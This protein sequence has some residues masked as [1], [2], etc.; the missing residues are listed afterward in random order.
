MTRGRLVAVGVG[1][2]LLAAV[3]WSQYWIVTGRVGTV[4]QGRLYR[5]AGLPPERLLGLVRQHNITTV[6]DFRKTGAETQAE[7]AAVEQAGIRYVPIPSEQVPS[8]DAVARFLDVMDSQSPGAVLI[9]CTHGAGR[10]GV[11][12]AIYR[13]E[14]Q[15]WSRTRA[16]TEAM[17]YAGF[18]SF[19]PWN[20]KTVFLYGY[21]PRSKARPR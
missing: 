20:A 18:G 4:V 19:G 6:V 1:I 8:P 11:F 13:M 14:Y 15:G 2:A 16:V 12:T 7:R 9:H 17:L 3:I 5:S 21:T 10:T